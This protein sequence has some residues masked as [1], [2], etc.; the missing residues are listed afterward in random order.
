VGTALGLVIGLSGAVGISLGG[1]LADRLARRDLR[2]SLWMVCVAVIVNVPFAF[3]VFLAE[4]PRAALACMIVPFLLGNF[5]QGVSLA[6][7][8]GLVEPRMR[9]VA[10][11][12]LLFIVNIIGLGAGPQFVG[13]VSDLLRATHGQDSLRYALLLCSGVNLWAAFHYYLAG[14]ALPAELASQAAR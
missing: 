3:G 5:W 9:A 1:Y 2:W 14:R 6:H 11:A 7:T 4:T 8:Q 10:A 13:I 12:V